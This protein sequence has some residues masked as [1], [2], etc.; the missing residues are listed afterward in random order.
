MKK[1]MAKLTLFDYIETK[2]KKLIDGKKYNTQR[3]IISNA[4]KERLNYYKLEDYIEDV[5]NLGLE[6]T[7]DEMFA[8]AAKHKPEQ[9]SDLFPFWRL[10]EMQTVKIERIVPQFPLSKDILKY[11]R[12]IKILSLYRLSLGQPRQEEFIESIIKDKINKEELEKLF[13][14][15]S[16]FYHQKETERQ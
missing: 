16:P 5:E 9:T 6:K 4:V 3:I 13:I 12:L 8:V 7:W 1:D 11:D 14:N 15:L 10:G 2:P